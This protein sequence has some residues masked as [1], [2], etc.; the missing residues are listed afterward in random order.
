MRKTE[1]QLADELDAFLKAKLTG[2]DLP[3]SDDLPEDEAKLAA[4][5]V[6]LAASTTPDP[7]FLAE[8][9]EK[10]A[11]S[12]ER[13]TS[14]QPTSKKSERPERPT[15]WQEFISSIR[16]FF[17]M[18]RMI[19]SVGAVAAVFVFAVFAWTALKNGGSEEDTPVV[20]DVTT[21]DSEDVTGTDDVTDTEEDA[22]GPT[23][24]TST[25][26]DNAGSTDG[27]GAIAEPT[28]L[29]LLP[30]M[31][32]EQRGGTPAIGKGGGGGLE[33]AP[34]PAAEGPVT[35]ESAMLI[36][37]DFTQVFADASYVLNATLPIEPT[38]ALVQQR[39]FSQPELADAR[40]IAERFGFTGPLYTEVFDLRP[41]PLP[42]VE[43]LIAPAEEGEESAEGRPPKEENVVFEPPKTYFAF[44]GDRMLNIHAE[45]Y[46]YFDR[47]I[48]IDYEEA[49]ANATQIAELFLQER[50]M[51]DFDYVVERGF[52]DSEVMVYRI[53]EGMPLS[54]P[55][56]FV[57]V[58]S[59][60]QVAMVSN[61]KAFS[62]LLTLGSYPLISAEAAWQRI[63]EGVVA[64]NVSFNIM[65]DFERMP[66]TTVIE[67]PFERPQFW[68]R[69]YQPG[70][71]VHLYAWPMVYRVAEGEGSPRI[72]AERFVLSGNDADLQAI[73]DQTGQMFHFWGQ[74]GTGDAIFEL[75]GW[76]S[77]PEPTP[78]H[79]GGDIQR[80]AD[81]ALFL[82]DNGQTFII[83]EAPAD[84][85][86]GLRVNIFAW[87]SREVGLEYPILDWQNIDE[88]FDFSS[89]PIAMPMPEPAVIEEEFVDP[90]SFAQITINEVK[91]TF[92]ITF[93]F[94][95]FDQRT[96]PPEY[97]QP[98]WQFSGVTDNGDNID[99][100]V[101]AVDPD[102]LQAP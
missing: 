41:M 47:G 12:T 64:N 50:G 95:N 38:T 20:A 72:E 24:G 2:Q 4:E 94:E 53:V 25:D 21:P 76:E 70:S 101:Q 82:S 102:F 56:I 91:L 9:E 35:S 75:A 62:Q 27:G 8:L 93:D 16:R 17:T 48:Q 71:E 40:L 61:Y 79:M 92:Q 55:E 22:G 68:Y 83:P 99:L 13:A 46:T 51:L 42:A 85:P 90:F 89:E 15:F 36:A 84:L 44:D 26:A 45:G 52:A 37:P 28:E 59:N 23:E 98:V 66:E 65:P 29:A 96:R 73:A 63:L 60:G 5:L 43:P 86:D 74:I 78:L 6:R 19:Y 39:I 100:R 11:R 30:R 31:D 77:L 14:R 54:D 1:Q 80:T 87:A 18:K 33:S 34:A 67:R 32:A 69:E 3:A 81:Q 88:W 97:V 10:M 49:V 58:A 57:Q 7:T